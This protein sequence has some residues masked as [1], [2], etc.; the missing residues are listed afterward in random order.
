[1]QE[2]NT[3]LRRAIRTI[4]REVRPDDRLVLQQRIQEATMLIGNNN[5]IHT[6]DTLQPENTVVELGSII[7]RKND[8]YIS[9]PTNHLRQR[10]RVTR[11]VSKQSPNSAICAPAMMGRDT[12]I[13]PDPFQRHRCDNAVAA[14]LPFLGGGAFT[15]AGR[16]FWHIVKKLETGKHPSPSLQENPFVKGPLRFSD[17]LHKSKVFQ[18]IEPSRWVAMIEARLAYREPQPD[19]HDADNMSLGSPI[20]S[21]ERTQAE[22]NHSDSNVNWLSI[23]SAEERIRAVVG[24]EVFAV[25]ATPGLD[26][27]ED[28]NR[29]T[30]SQHSVTIIDDLLDSLSESFVCFGNGPQWTM[31]TFDGALRQWCYSVINP[32][33]QTVTLPP[34]CQYVGG[35]GGS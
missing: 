8:Y 25:L 20:K 28:N 21:V 32:Y 18:D 11:C 9:R 22:V 19:P 15:V 3:A 1:M 4:A 10:T 7:S 31:E 29:I 17:L 16:I 26:S 35:Q 30:H 34:V 33:L 2:E 27:H 24:D 6:V 13:A 12:G 5:H 23:M 14:V